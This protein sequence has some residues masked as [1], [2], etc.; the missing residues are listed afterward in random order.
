M[1]KMIFIGGPCVIE[2][3][4]EMLFEV[5]K[6][7]KD[8]SNRLDFEFIFKSSFDK[9]NRSSISSYRGPGLEKAMDL[10]KRIKDELD[11]KIVVDIH[12]PEQADMVS[13]VVDVI[14]IPAFLCRQTD[15]LIA[16]GNTGKII[17]IK[18]GQFLSPEDMR[19]AVKKVESTGNKT[20]MITERGT[21][22]GYHNLVVDM[23]SFPIMKS[24]GYP[25]I[26]DATHSV[27]L[28][29]G[30]NGITGGQREFIPSLA[31]AAIASGADGV[32]MEIHPD[33]ECALCDSTNQYYLDKAEVLL[34]RL[35]KIYKVVSDE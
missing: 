26:F 13:K 35:S 9:A 15:L 14:Q 30:S 28:P 16:A 34:S 4:D 32:F 1:K 18:K 11:V 25:V 24:L 27:Q 23:R 29:G 12:I 3:D 19:F 22:F 17:N 6:K 21:S 31:K 33:P 7:L 5:C 8:I 2:H 10:L 20:I